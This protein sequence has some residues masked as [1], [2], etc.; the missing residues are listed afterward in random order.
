[1]MRC[2]RFVIVPLL[3]I[4]TVSPVTWAQIYPARPIR[5]IV[6]LPP[7]GAIDIVARIIGQKVGESVK[8]QI[9]IDNRLGASGIIAAEITAKAAPDGYT[10]FMHAITNHTISASLYKKLPY[11]SVKD[12]AAVI[13][14]ASAPIVLVANPSLP[15]NSV[16]ELIALARA[17]PGQI[18]FAS[19][20]SGGTT[21]LAGELLKFMANINLTHVPYK[22]GPLAMTDVISGQM[23]LLFFSLP[24]ALPQIKAGRVKAIAVTSTKR[25]TA[26]PEIPTVAESG[27]AG[28]EVGVVIGLLA[29]AAT[30]KQIVG[31]LNAEILQALHSPDVAHA[32]SRQGSDP[33]GSTPGE[34]E[35]YLKSEVAKWAKVIRAIDLRA[36]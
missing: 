6:G 20:G 11:D 21:H 18:N 26:A 34:F 35:S 9:V 29:P 14:V 4:A 10:L 7:G 17:R 28:F 16:T 33:L 13:L 27:L 32:I 1:M 3:F 31:K 2:A 24:G 25:S 19:S 36:D 22:G 15:A 8:Q 30:P 23:Q 12:F 5:L